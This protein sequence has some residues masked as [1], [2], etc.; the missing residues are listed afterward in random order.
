MNSES[1]TGAPPAPEEKPRSYEWGELQCGNEPTINDPDGCTQTHLA[2]YDKE[3]E[4]IFAQV[5]G[6]PM[7]SWLFHYRGQ[8]QGAYMTQYAAKQAAQSYHAKTMANGPEP[9]PMVRGFQA[10]LPEMIAAINK[11]KPGQAGGALL[12][13]R[14]GELMEIPNFFSPE[15]LAAVNPADIVPA[16]TLPACND[17]GHPAVKHLND[18]NGNYRCSDFE[19][20]ATVTCT[21]ENYSYA[22]GETLPK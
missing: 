18:G 22:K 20:A 21:C 13:P 12:N 11:L 16:L 4:E 8:A 2:Y 17:C 9:S 5:D 6:R 7:G 3:T 10:A 19:K 1:P 15:G 14:T